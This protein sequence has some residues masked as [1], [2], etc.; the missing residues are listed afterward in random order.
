MKLFLNIIW[1]KFDKTEGIKT[2]LQLFPENIN[3]KISK[4]NIKIM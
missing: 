1:V 3:E 2:K 4:Q